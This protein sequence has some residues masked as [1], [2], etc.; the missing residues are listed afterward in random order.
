MP[1]FTEVETPMNFDF[2]GHTVVYDMLGNDVKIRYLDDTDIDLFFMKH[3]LSNP[4]LSAPEMRDAFNLFLVTFVNRSNE[5]ITFNPVSCAIYVDGSYFRGALDY[6]EVVVG[7]RRLA[8]EADATSFKKSMFS[9]ALDI[10]PG[11]SIEGLLVFP[12]MP[13][14]TKHIVVMV[15]GIIFSGT[16]YSIPFEFVGK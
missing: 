6:A 9:A 2:E 7:F 5:E 14:K 10:E 1:R 3:D 16:S 8:P 4:F 15:K 12:S 11:T 13:R